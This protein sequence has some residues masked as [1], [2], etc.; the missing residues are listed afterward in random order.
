MTPIGEACSRRAATTPGYED[1]VN[2]YVGNEVTL[3]YD[4]GI[5]GLAAFGV[6][7]QRAALRL[8]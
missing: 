8:P 6:H 2:D 5:V 1:D 7:L 4:T 3:E